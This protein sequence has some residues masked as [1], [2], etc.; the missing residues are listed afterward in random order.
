[1]WGQKRRAR[2]ERCESWF[3]LRGAMKP[4]QAAQLPEPGR[5]P[6][7]SGVVTSLTSP[8]GEKGSL[9]LLAQGES[10][11]CAQPAP[12]AYRPH[13]FTV[14]SRPAR[15]DNKNCTLNALNFHILV[16]HVET[17][18]SLHFKE[19]IQLFLVIGIPK[20]QGNLAQRHKLAIRWS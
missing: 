20:Q 2:K 7:G 18:Q 17:S 14:Q 11:L 3:Y 9:P 12:A 4:G 13:F 16:L 19:R 8:P 10:W 6:L 5:A 15:G 1:M